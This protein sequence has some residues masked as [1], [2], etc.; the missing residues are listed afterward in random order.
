MTKAEW[1]ALVLRS[2]VAVKA[3]PELA[4]RVGEILADW[5]WAE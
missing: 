2:L 1:F 5:E 3:S 4:T